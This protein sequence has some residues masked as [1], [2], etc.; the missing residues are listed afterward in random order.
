MKPILCSPAS[1]IPGS[2]MPQNGFVP[3]SRISPHHWE[4]IPTLWH[5][6]HLAEQDESLRQWIPY[7]LLMRSQS[8]AAYPRSGTENRLWNLWSVGFGGHVEVQDQ[9]SSL[10]A[11]LIACA[12]REVLEETGLVLPES[13]FEPLGLVHE[14]VSP[15]G[16]VHLGLVF[17]VKLAAY[18]NI[19]ITSE[20]LSYQWWIPSKP[21]HQLE[22]WS[23][24][25][26]Q[27]LDVVDH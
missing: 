20:I 10:L 27:L 9:R 6:R 25:A 7:C 4:Q 22:S 12:K 15:V 16:R 18:Q 21:L 19:R 13:I 24:L 1:Q 17:R 23:C 5:P 3:A 26:L 2:W 8:V 14:S 11:T